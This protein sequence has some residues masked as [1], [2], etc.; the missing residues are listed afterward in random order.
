MFYKREMRR[1]AVRTR[2]FVMNVTACHVPRKE[3]TRS[4]VTMRGAEA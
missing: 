3:R 4:D 1:R 2:T